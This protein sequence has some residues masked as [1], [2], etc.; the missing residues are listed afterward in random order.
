MGDTMKLPLMQLPRLPVVAFVGAW[1]SGCAFT[2]QTAEIKPTVQV[3]ASNI[4]QGKT[5]GVLVTDERDTQDLGNR[6]SALISKAAKISSDQNLAEVFRQAVFDG[7]K[8]KS[9]MPKDLNG[10]VD[11]QLKVEIRSLNYSTST[12]FWTGGVDT[13]AA[14]KAIATA[15]GKS[16]ENIYRSNNEERVVVV[17]TAEHNSELL[18]KVVNDVLSK[19]FEDQ[20]LLSTLAS[21]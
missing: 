9:F 4:G 1:L 12:G 5:V 16:Y 6:G 19:L 14:I 18:N 21:N 15:S 11:R 7:L 10:A 8:S 2:P 17:P 20:A 13:K 3:Y